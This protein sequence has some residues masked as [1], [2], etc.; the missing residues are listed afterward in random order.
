MCHRTPTPHHP[1]CSGARQLCHCVGTQAL[2]VSCNL[3]PGFS[4][5]LYSEYISEN[6]NR[7][8]LHST[9]FYCVTYFG[10]PTNDCNMAPHCD[11]LHRVIYLQSV[12]ETLKSDINALLS[13]RRIKSSICSDSWNPHCLDSICSNQLFNVIWFSKLMERM[14]WLYVNLCV[15]ATVHRF[16]VF[17]DLPGTGGRGARLHERRCVKLRHVCACN[18]RDV[19]CCYVSKEHSKN[20]F[21]NPVNKTRLKDV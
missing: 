11:W 1:L 12:H 19:I 13:F 5:L 10:S 2:P 18:G 21:L 20:F 15:E 16:V 17:V 14:W 4:Q 8:M 9:T 7:L 6:H 3:P